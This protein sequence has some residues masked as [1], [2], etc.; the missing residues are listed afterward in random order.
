VGIKVFGDDLDLLKEKADEIRRAVEK[1]PGAEDVT[2]EQVAGQ[3]TLSIEID[4]AAAGR[5]GIPVS[6]ILDAVEA[7]GTPKYGAVFDGQRRFDLVLRLDDEARQSEQSMGETPI[8]TKSGT[9]VPLKAVTRIQFAE[10]PSTIQREWA[11]RR[12]VVSL[13]VRGRDIASFVAQVRQLLDQRIALPSGYF[14]RLGGQF[15][16]LERAQKRLLLI[17]PI[18]LVLVFTLLLITYGR[19][20][21]A[22]RVFVGVPFGV[23][24]GIFALWVRDM[25]FSISAGVGFIALSGVSVLGDMVL[26]SRV[27]QLSALG[28]APL[29][30]IREAAESRLRPVLI[31][32]LVAAL[33]FIPM[34]LNTGIG[35]EIQRPLA[36]VVI[37][38]MVTSTLATLV[39]L[40]VLYA[41]IGGSSSKQAR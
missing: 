30:A 5:Y 15:E 28:R 13:N 29:V 39:V 11:K 3:R 27:R 32:A 10:S 34:A 12:V 33:G 40:P 36:T 25:P 37:G 20:A 22:L 35:A 23:V 31:T 8:R 21:D 6:K 9:L 7:F 17:V 24:G 2:V 1:L 19:A 26:V 18:A 14:T 38:G 4:R 41:M 16:N